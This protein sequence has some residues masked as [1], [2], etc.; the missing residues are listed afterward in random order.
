MIARYSLVLLCYI[1]GTQKLYSWGQK[2]PPMTDL[3][4]IINTFE[5]MLTP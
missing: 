5:E 4:K 2:E 1:F 3:R